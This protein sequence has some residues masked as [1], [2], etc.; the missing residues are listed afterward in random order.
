MTTVNNTPAV[1]HKFFNSFDDVTGDFGVAQPDVSDVTGAVAATTTVN[2]HALSSNV[3]VTKGDVGLG[4][5]VNADTTTT[6]NISDSVDKRFITDAQQTVLGNTSNTNTGDQDLSGLAL[7]S[8]TV[9]GHALSSNV[10]V[11]AADVGAPSGSGTS[12][13]TNTGDQDLSGL[14]LKSTTVNGH[15]LSSNVTVSKSDVGLGS[16]VNADTT[17]T[18]NISD[19]TNKRF[20]TDAELAVLATLGAITE[21]D[22]TMAVSTGGGSVT[23]NG[24]YNKLHWVSD[25]KRVT[26]SGYL[27]VASV[28]SP[29]GTL[30]FTGLPFTVKNDISCRCA[31]AVMGNNFNT[32][33]GALEGVIQENTSAIKL[34]QQSGGGLAD[35]ANKLAAGTDF[36]F[37][38]TY[39]I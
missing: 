14:A 38:F 9:N 5:V 33:I 24:S 13:G 15:A 25:G 11:T 12:S 4:S 23:L 21:G 1:A 8:T 18:T 6:A 37:N 3:T 16:V 29:T 27:Y 26:V 30:S 39:F 19:A 22:A 28:S 35:L 36:A 20:V 32:G 34:Y 2:G 17:T 10:T 31:V 7:K